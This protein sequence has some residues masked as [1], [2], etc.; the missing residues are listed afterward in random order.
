MRLFRHGSR[1]LWLAMIVVSLS[2]FMLHGVSAKTIASSFAVSVSP[3]PVVLQSGPQG[4]SGQFDVQVQG[5]TPNET[6]F[7]PPAFLLERSC[8]VTGLPAYIQADS[9]GNATRHVM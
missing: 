8:D 9:S 6:V 4:L 7:L 1:L 2:T 5:A 3:D